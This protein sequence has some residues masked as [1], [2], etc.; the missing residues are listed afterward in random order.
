VQRNTD[1]AGPPS[2][3]AKGWRRAGAATAAA[4]A[5]DPN[6]DGWVLRGLAIGQTEV[7]VG[8]DFRTIGG[9]PRNRIAALDK[10]SGEATDWD[11]DADADVFALALDGSRVYAGGSFERVGGEHRRS[12]A[13]LDRATGAAEDWDPDAAEGPVWTLASGGPVLYAGGQFRAVGGL[14][15]SSLA[16]IAISAAGASVSAGDGP[17]PVLQNEPNPFG[18]KTV[19]RFSLAAPEQVTLSVFDLA[20]RELA[21]PLRGARL[22]PGPQQVAFDGSTLP[23]GIYMCRL[24]AGRSIHTKRMVVV[25]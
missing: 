15:Q 22:G 4:T 11:P 7:Y 1:S 17:A 10:V 13:A 24:Q 3:A 9:K 12:I 19:I 14:P 5:W 23:A 16:S 25:R 21:S 6:P 20:G 8:G 2:R 18:D